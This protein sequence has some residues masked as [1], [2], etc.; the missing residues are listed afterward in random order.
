MIFGA[1]MTS[2]RHSPNDVNYGTVFKF[3][4][5]PYNKSSPDPP[6]PLVSPGSPPEP[7]ATVATQRH[8]LRRCHCIP[9]PTPCARLE[10]APKRLWPRRRILPGEAVTRAVGLAPPGIPRGHTR[11][12]SRGTEDGG[13]GHAQIRPCFKLLKRHYQEGG[14]HEQGGKGGK[15]VVHNAEKKQQGR[16]D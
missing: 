7:V 5:K 4:I 11:T 16:E 2:V 15:G 3:G 10:A 13:E 12:E 1:M 6:A 9:P 8:H 14:G